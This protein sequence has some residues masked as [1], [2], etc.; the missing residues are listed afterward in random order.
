M[1]AATSPSLARERG[2]RALGEL[3]KESGAQAIASEAEALAARIAEGRFYVACI[4]QFK[5]GKSTLLNALTGTNVLPMGVAPVTAVITVVRY[6]ERAA[7]R[8]QFEGGI[9]REIDPADLAA[10]VAEE[11]NP[12]NVKRVVA[13]EVFAPSPLLATGMCLV[14]T[15]GLGSVFRTNTQATQNFVPHIDAALIVLGADPPISGEELD[16]VENVG[17]EVHDFIFVLN[18]ADRLP[19]ADRR[20]AS[21]FSERVIAERLRRPVECVFEISATEC[22]GSGKAS[23]DWR[24]LEEKLRELGAT[25]GAGLVQA[26]CERGRRRLGEDLAAELEEQRGALSRPVAESE[27]RLDALRGYVSDATRALGDLGHLFA[28]EQEAL[29]HTF[30]QYRGAFLEKVRPIAERE[31]REAIETTPERRGPS[32]RRRATSLALEISRRHVGEWLHDVGPV[33]EDLYRRATERFVSLA[34]GFLERLAATGT[35]EM[36][37]LARPLEPETGFRARSRFYHHELVMLTGLTP[38][39]WLLDLVR[40]RA[41]ALRVI[42]SDATAY[43]GRLLDTNAARVENDWDERVLESRRVLEHEIRN[44]LREI[45]ASAERALERARQHH[46]EGTGAVRTA[47]ERIDILQHRLESLAHDPSVSTAPN[48]DYPI[49]GPSRW[50]P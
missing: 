46:T 37:R 41:K 22:L 18:K 5:R 30:A 29:G 50:R 19:E 16:M 23:R 11:H 10:Y 31:L 28:A 1:V 43:L 44:R 42:T 13:A 12:K 38:D 15:P 35:P 36:G 34:N 48:T 14:D 2:L 40:S 9:W 27:Q 7:A 39:V 6:G 32:L 33:A 17:R 4:G 8:V 25:S 47:L 26:A 49:G 21:A 45:T 20:E 3:A 24:S